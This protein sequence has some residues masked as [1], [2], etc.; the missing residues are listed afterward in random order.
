M[1]KQ[2]Q[3]FD[4]ARDKDGDANRDPITKAPGAHPIG[5]GVGA[6]V[7]GVAGAAA[8]GVAASAMAGAA[9]GTTAGPIGTAAGLVIGA[10]VGGLAGKGVA[11]KIDP[12]KEDAYWRTQYTKEPYFAQGARYE[13]YHPA[14]RTAYQHYGKYAGRKFDEVEPTLRSSYEKDRGDSTLGWDRARDASRSAWDRLE[15]MVP[16]DSD[17]DGK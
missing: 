13:D 7:G 9:V 8:A 15:R 17:R 10:I 4:A 1:N 11:E 2:Q 14:Y 12:T 5:T 6:T 16:G 3:Q